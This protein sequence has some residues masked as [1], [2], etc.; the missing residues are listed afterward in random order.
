MADAHC[1]RW[2]TVASRGWP[3][4]CCRFF[5]WDNITTADPSLLV[6]N[7]LA[8]DGF[9]L[10]VTIAICAA[11]RPRRAVHRDYLRRERL[12]GPEV[13]ALYLLA[14]VGGMVMALRQRPHRA[15]PRPGDRCRSR[16]T[17]WRPAT[18]G[19]SRARRAASSTSCSV[20]S[21][22]RSSS[23]AS[24]W[25]T[26]PPAS[27]NFSGDRRLFNDNVPARP[28][29]RARAR[30]HGPAA[31]RPRLQ[32]RRGAVPLLDA[33][34][35]PGRA[36]AG[37]RRS[38]RRSARRRRSPR[39]CGCSIVALPHYSDDWR[40]VVWVLAVLTLLVG[41]VMAVVQTD[42]KRMLAYSSISH[43]GFILVGVEA[44]AHTAGQPDR[45]RHLGRAVL[46]AALRGDGARHLRAWSRWWAAPATRATD[47][48]AFRGPV[49]SRSPL[50]ALA[51]TVLLLAQAGVPLTRGF[52]A[53]FG[54]IQAAVE[55]QQ[56]RA[57]RSSPW[58]PP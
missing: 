10:F 30:R 46:P 2:F 21:R 29:R 18:A 41:S 4:S 58:S 35:V 26:A 28:Q 20:A 37:H 1:T 16:S 44:A 32:G 40:P 52:V 19:G 54:V 22:R 13:Y 45:R 51:F 39:C 6:G 5:L 8:F 55:V 14:A 38:W 25:S 50:L 24:P 7:A 48:D 11:R 27:T 42:V 56:L 3:P 12:D 17:C 36:H 47:L 15:V 43:A 31:R 57:R 49:A 53:K 33:R 34:R 23:T 9:A